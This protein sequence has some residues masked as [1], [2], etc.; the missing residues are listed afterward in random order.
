M[1]QYDIV[2]LLDCN[3]ITCTVYLHMLGPLSQA[4][5]KKRMNQAITINECMNVMSKRAIKA[6]FKKKKFSEILPLTLDKR[7]NFKLTKTLIHFLRKTN[8]SSITWWQVIKLQERVKGWTSVKGEKQ[9]T[10]EKVLTLWKNGKT[11]WEKWTF[12]NSETSCNENS[13]KGVKSNGTLPIPQ[14]KPFGLKPWN[15]TSRWLHTNSINV[16]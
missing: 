13:Q 6:S 3:F 15:L 5:S 2:N 1:Q 16:L 9:K 8:D 12:Q 11:I 10:F 7:T 4:E 14:Q